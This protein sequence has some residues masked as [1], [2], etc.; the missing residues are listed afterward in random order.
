MDKRQGLWIWILCIALLGSCVAAAGKQRDPMA[1]AR[2]QRGIGLPEWDELWILG[3]APREPGKPSGLLAETPGLSPLPLESLDVRAHLVGPLA[4]V[5]VRQR[6]SNPHDRELNAQYELPLPRDAA[7]SDFVMTIGQR[8]IRGI[9][10]ERE[11]ARSIFFSAKRQGLLTTLL[12]ESPST[13]ITLSVANIAPRSSIDVELEYFQGLPHVDG[14]RELALPCFQARAGQESLEINVE[15][16]I[17]ITRV[18][19]SDPD[20]VL[21]RSAADRITIRSSSVVSGHSE[22]F[23]RYELAQGEPAGILW[24]RGTETDAHFLLEVHAPTAGTGRRGAVLTELEIDWGALA[25]QDVLPA[26]PDALRSGRPLVLVGRCELQHNEREHL[27][28]LRGKAGGERRSLSLS[29]DVRNC[30]DEGEILPRMWARL[31]IAELTRHSLVE[32][33]NSRILDDLDRIREL[34][35]EYGLSTFFTAFVTV[36]ALSTQSHENP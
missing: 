31:L 12:E 36:D 33:R 3:R 34:G 25:V 19:C 28:Q 16:G 32:E 26:L 22:P 13:P 1:W 18:E 7:I 6:F 24:T 2:N 17:E 14:W 5:A 20:A 30:A 27:I 11:E 21:E 35:L 8:R 10:R 29:V 9:V 4:T 23:L 15:A